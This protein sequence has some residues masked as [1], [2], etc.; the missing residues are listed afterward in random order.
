MS[1][2]LLLQNSS[3]YLN[4]D[5]FLNLISDQGVCVLS[6][7]LLNQTHIDTFWQTYYGSSVPRV[8]ICGINPGRHG[9]GKTGIPFLDFQSLAQLI[10]G[11]ERSDSEGSAGFFYQVVKRVGASAFFPTFYVTNIASVGFA[12]E[13]KN[14]NYNELP[15]PALEIVERNFL[16]EMAVVQPTHIISLGEVVHATVNKLMG[17]EVDCTR[18]LPH[19][20]WITTYRRNESEK[21][22]SHY[23]AE[24]GPFLE[25]THKER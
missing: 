9:A 11:V 1:N 5:G 21:W 14:L 6:D 4:D 13:G 7:L 23:L 20:S 15:G 3:R 17:K 12:C 2:N 19:P 22:L 10:P 25:E 18:R 8:V 16:L 24:L